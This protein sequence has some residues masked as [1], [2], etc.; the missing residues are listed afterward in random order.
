LQAERDGA[1]YIGAGPVYPTL[2][3]TD[4][5]PSIG[6]SGLIQIKQAVYLPVVAIGGINLTNARK[7]AEIADGIAV[8]SAVA[9]AADPRDAVRKL[10]EIINNKG[11]KP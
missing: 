9:Q 10:S 11:K 5:D 1:D 2:S 4:A 8:I 6:I 3:K 7:V